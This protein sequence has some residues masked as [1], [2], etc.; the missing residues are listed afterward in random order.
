MMTYAETIELREKLEN[1][2]IS[3]GKAR[4]I[5]FADTKEGKRSWHTKDWK[6]R[7]NLIIKEKCEQCGG[8]E[9][10]VLQH[11]SHP[12][13]YDEYYQ[14]AYWHFY[15]IFTEEKFDILVAKE[16]IENYISNKTREIFN[17]CPKCGWNFRTRIKEPQFVCTNCKY[18]FKEPAQKPLPEYFDDMYSNSIVPVFDK[19]SNAPGNRK[20]PYIMLYSEIKQK[21]I[22]NPAAE[23]R[24]MLF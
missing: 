7:R 10:L 21:I 3:P 24:G 17:M 18:E 20:V 1:N 14:K 16:D 5:Y 15:Y 13:K 2:A 12:E 23:Q 4:E 11:L 22:N 19:P 6:D 8:T 9:N